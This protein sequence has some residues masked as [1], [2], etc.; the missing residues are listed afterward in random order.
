MVQ[1]NRIPAERKFYCWSSIA[2]AAVI[3]LGHMHGEW[4]MIGQFAVSKAGHDKGELYVVVA[5]E[6][7]Y[8]FLCDGRTKTPD[9]PKKKK[10]KHIQP[11][12]KNVGA[13]LLQKLQ[14]GGKV[15]PEEIRYALR[16]LQQRNETQ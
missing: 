14:T 1:D 5:Q 3:C 6:G 4:K 10:I 7:E 11:V 13:E 15:Y 12:K 8:V 16:Q 2:D 9:K